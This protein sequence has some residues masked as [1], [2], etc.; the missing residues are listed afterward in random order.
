MRRSIRQR[1]A[2]SKGD[3]VKKA[4]TFALWI[5]FICAIG[6]VIAPP[7]QAQLGPNVAPIY[8]SVP[9]S[10]STA[11]PAPTPSP[12]VLGN[13]LGRTWCVVNLEG[14]FAATYTVEVNQDGL[15]QGTGVW[16]TP[17]PSFAQVA[18][19]PPNTISAAGSQMYHIPGVYAIRA[20]M[21]TRT[22]GA[23]IVTLVCQ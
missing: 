3:I 4:T 9:Q 13:I 2:H 7:A 21:T 16:H 19:P 11:S 15:Y 5:V 17:D 20:R 18:S 10:A 22:S 8:T 23:P 1:I 12:V 14:T 6:L